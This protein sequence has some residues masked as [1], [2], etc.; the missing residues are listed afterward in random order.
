MINNHCYSQC[1]CII[2][3]YTW[4]IYIYTYLCDMH[5]AYIGLWLHRTSNKRFLVY[6]LSRY[7]SSFTLP[8]YA[9]L[10]NFLFPSTTYFLCTKFVAYG[11]DQTSFWGVSLCCLSTFCLIAWGVIY[12]SYGSGISIRNTLYMFMHAYTLVPLMLAWYTPNTLLL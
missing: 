1:V 5:N 6:R 9:T 4:V 11:S 12:L 3:R 10:K 8:L 7:K 2:L